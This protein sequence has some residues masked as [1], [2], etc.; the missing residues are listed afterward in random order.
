VSNRN[1]AADYDLDM[2]RAKAAG[3]D[4]F[5][6]NIGTNWFTEQQLN[7]AYESANN[8]GMKVFISFDFAW[9]NAYDTGVATQV[10]QMIAKYGSR[11][12]QLKYNNKIFASSFVGDGLN[13]NIMRQAAGVD[14]YWVP[15]F[16]PGSSDP[17][18]IDGAF[19]WM[20]RLS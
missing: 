19:N 8:N 13:T 12:A 15:N 14:V 7:Y 10:G 4:A 11:P 18:P 3:I 1:S 5:A 16:H 2:K 9:Y 17:S 20:V 6:L